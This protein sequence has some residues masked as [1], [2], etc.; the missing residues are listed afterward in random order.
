MRIVLLA[1][2]LTCMS[3]CTPVGKDITTSYEQIPDELRD[4]SIYFMRNKAGNDLH[5]IRCPSASTTV[6]QG[7]SSSQHRPPKKVSTTVTD[8]ESSEE[9]I[10]D[11]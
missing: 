2:A 3:A 8:Y 6:Q 10:N 1:L 11:R 5:V 7:Q 4:C 9:E